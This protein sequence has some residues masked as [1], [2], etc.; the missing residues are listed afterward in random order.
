[1]K[2][3]LLWWALAFILAGCSDSQPPSV[4]T[5]EQIQELHL[6]KSS[7]LVEPEKHHK[8]AMEEQPFNW[9]VDR[10]A[11]LRILRYQVPGFEQL[12]LAQKQLLYF[13]SQAA[14]AG[15]DIIWDQNYHLNLTIRRTLEQIVECFK[16]DRESELFKRFMLY[17]K[18]VWF[19]NGIHHHYSNRKFNPTFSLAELKQLINQTE[20]ANFPLDKGETV[21]DLI[22]NIEDAIF[23][24]AYD[25]RKVDKSKGVDNVKNSAVNFY[26]DV[27]EQETRDFYAAKKNADD[28]TPPSYGLNSQLVKQ[29]GKI[30]ERV[31][32]VGG[33]YSEA[34][35][36]VVYWLKKASS[37][38]ENKQQK[39]ALDLLIKFYQ[40]GD[41]K[42]F[43]EYSIAWVKDINS[44][45]DVINGFIEVYNDPVAYR[46]SYESVVSVRNPEA[47]KVIAAIAKKAQWFEDNMP[48]DKAF[49]KSQVKGITGKSIIVVMEAGD[50][51]PSTPIGINLPNANWIRAQHGSK[52]VS[53]GNIVNA[54]EQAQ[55]KGLE[56]F[57]WD[58]NEI[59]RAKKYSAIASSLHTDMHEVIGHASGKINPGVGTPKET[60][61][62]YSSTLEEAR[63][64]LVGLYYVPDPML[65]EIGVSPSID[66][67]KVAYDSYIRKGLM[68]QLQRIKPGENIE[69][70][71]MRNRQLVAAWA[72]QQG[73]KDNVI[74]KR[75]R[76]DKTYFVVNDY[77]KLRKLFGELLG[78]IQRIKSEGDFSAAEMLVETYG[79]KVDHAIHKEVLKRYQSLDVAPYSGFVNPVLLPIMDGDNII[80]VE[81]RQ[82]KDFQTQMLD[83]AKNHSYLPNKN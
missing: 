68:T 51:S 34:L 76:D 32:K 54:Y 15:R 40:T 1:M 49:K 39:K 29:D 22:V 78:E 23:D 66:V 18:Q 5:N 33:M 31:W 27:S 48:M 21:D 81:I 11:D 43:D 55:G 67:G 30:F 26:R 42:D 71:H 12:P 64:D 56:E 6:S 14:L 65:V 8:H 10:F 53:L 4:D 75:I 79:V 60:L 17:T 38:A 41:L 61:K 69:E 19:A 2:K 52:S 45:I 80:D 50:A 37:V 24:L 82:V 9:V 7:D 16:G 36:Q 28:H 13:L 20:G 58:N 59:D 62:Q 44:D 63:A 83:Y 25:S 74:E 47:T 77:E 73:E 3:H 46:G 35:E 70:D 72:Y 57:A